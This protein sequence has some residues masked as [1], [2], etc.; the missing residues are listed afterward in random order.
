MSAGHGVRAGSQGFADDARQAVSRAEPDGIMKRGSTL[1]FMIDLV[2]G[3]RLRRDRRTAVSCAAR[4]RLR[5][6]VLVRRCLASHRLAFFFPVPPFGCRRI[7][8]ELLGG[9]GV[10]SEESKRRVSTRHTRASVDPLELLREFC[11]RSP[12]QSGHGFSRSGTYSFRATRSIANPSP[13]GRQ[14]HDLVGEP[15]DR[16]ARLTSLD[17]SRQRHPSPLAARS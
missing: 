15:C 1:H 4:R 9:D 17:A 3:Q 16:S 2:L 5:G 8:G 13:A 10:S 12:G 11:F 14:I 7:L 6:H